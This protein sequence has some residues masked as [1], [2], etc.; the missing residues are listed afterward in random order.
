MFFLHSRKREFFK[1]K[2]LSN[3]KE[4]RPH[5]KYF[6]YGRLRDVV[7]SGRPFSNPSSG[8]KRARK[9]IPS[10][11]SDEV[12]RPHIQDPTWMRDKKDG[13]FTIR[14]PIKTHKEKSTYD[15]DHTFLFL[16]NISS[17]K[18]S[19]EKKRYIAKANGYREKPKRRRTPS[20]S[21][22]TPS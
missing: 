11:K 13:L 4:N 7:K 8:K 9:T 14:T 15:M 2:A 12:K 18:P 5:L 19:K 22:I 1:K 17:L 20:S 16:R 6:K 10:A 3:K 21:K